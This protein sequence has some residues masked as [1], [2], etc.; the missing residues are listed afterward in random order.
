MGD[1]GYL[2]KGFHYD[3]V[4][5]TPLILSG[6]GV[7]ASQR[8]DSMSSV[9][10]IAPTLLEMAGIEEPQSTQGISMR[11]TLTGGAATSRKAVLTENDDDLGRVRM[12]TITTR[13]WKLTAYAT[14]SLGELYDRRSDPEER[15]SRW[16]DPAH[17]DTKNMM[18]AMLLEDVM[19]RM[20]TLN[21]R[22]QA[23]VPPVWKWIPNHP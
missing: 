9:I 20:D 16:D 18:K 21:G 7:R 23:P 6:P 15:S 17:A 3:C 22:T 1:H 19:C 10:D 5:R 4:L 2:G 12:R 13:E 14:E 11:G 8:V